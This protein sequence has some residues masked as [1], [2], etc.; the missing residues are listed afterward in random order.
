[1]GD[2]RLSYSEFKAIFFEN[3]DMELNSPLRLIKTDRLISKPTQTSS[4]SNNV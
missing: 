2:G 1:M 3:D 4:R